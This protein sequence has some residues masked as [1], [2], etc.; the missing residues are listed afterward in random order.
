MVASR[1]F[2]LTILFRYALGDTDQ[3]RSFLFAMKTFFLF[4]SINFLTNIFQHTIIIIQEHSMAPQSTKQVRILILTK[5]PIKSPALFNIF[6]ILVVL[7]TKLASNMTVRAIKLLVVR[8]VTSHL[9]VLLNHRPIFIK[10]DLSFFN[11][12]LR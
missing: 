1:A 5:W 11:S 12:L 8:Y 2:D 4:C 3:A 7:L 6:D 9:I 10:M